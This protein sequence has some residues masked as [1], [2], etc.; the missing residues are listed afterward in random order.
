MPQILFHLMSNTDL[1]VGKLGRLR[2]EGDSIL[3]IIAES[4]LIGLGL[5]LGS[6]TADGYGRR[7]RP[8]VT[9]DAR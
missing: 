6:V 8:T 2:R 3:H 5:G 7:L 9:A 4:D 1:E